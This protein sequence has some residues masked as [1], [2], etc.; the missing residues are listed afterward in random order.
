MAVK[1]NRRLRSLPKK[2]SQLLRLAIRDIKR[3]KKD[4]KVEIYMGTWHQP[5]GVCKVCF[6]GAVMHYGLQ[7][8][9][10]SSGR[11]FLEPWLYG[12]KT[13]Q[14]L[15]ALN[16]FRSG[17]VQSGCDD[18]GIRSAIESR[19][20]PHAEQDFKGFIAAMEQLAEEFKA[21]GN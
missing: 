12:S 6:A 3:A 10:G 9:R 16:N 17:W 7:F 2:P 4:K 8:P 19:S 11:S 21:E 13:C 14:A 5:N 20:I 15:E 1:A 18:L